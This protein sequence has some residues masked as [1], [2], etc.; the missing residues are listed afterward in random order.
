MAD[1]ELDPASSIREFRT[2]EIQVHRRGLA[3]RI[4][5]CKQSLQDEMAAARGPTHRQA[6][7]L[8]GDSC[9]GLSRQIAAR[10]AVP[11]STA[12]MRELEFGGPCGG[13]AEQMMLRIAP[14]VA[15]SHGF[16]PDIDRL[17]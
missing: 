17:Q 5:T 10:G 4:S 6:L 1:G 3:A 13:A 7:Q 8:A 16:V 2:D 11:V 14:N 15:R 12:G 9:G